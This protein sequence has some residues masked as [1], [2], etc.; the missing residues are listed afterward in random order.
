LG[1]VRDPS[2]PARPVRRRYLLVGALGLL[3][4]G[5]A[6]CAPTSSGT[7]PT[8]VRSKVGPVLD[9]ADCRASATGERVVATGTVESAPG[10]PLALSLSVY[11]PAGATLDLEGT[12]H[13]ATLSPDAR[14]WQ[15]A[16]HLTRGYVPSRCTVTVTA[17]EDLQKLAI[18]TGSMA[19][20]IR[21]GDAVV[22]AVHGAP[23]PRLGDLVAFRPPAG[24]A[25]PGAGSVVV[26]RVV[27]TAGQQVSGVQNTVMV[28]GHALDEPWLTPAQRSGTGDFG[29][30][31]VP[32]GALYVLGDD[33]AH[34]CDSRVLGPLTSS[35][36]V[37]PVVRTD[38]ATHAATPPYQ[39]TTTPAIT[40]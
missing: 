28:D 29:P 37:G 13:T 9:H 33:R 8:L 4:A 18:T 14:R 6:A 19:P 17:A 11:S 10:R 21:A 2:H 30:T 39:E 5:V 16:A 31:S 1:V 25:C 20:T 12:S 22:I 26:G 15:V 27:G 24:A 34:A 3:A 7:L 36:L 35:E 23:A 38:K 40:S 32:A